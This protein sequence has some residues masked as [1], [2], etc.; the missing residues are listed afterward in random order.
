MQLGGGVDGNSITAGGARG[1]M[2]GSIDFADR[3]WRVGG[4]LA[5][6]GHGYPTDQ[7]SVAFE[8]VVDPFVD[9]RP[10]RST[11][12]RTIGEATGMKAAVER[13]QHVADNMGFHGVGA[14]R[15]TSR[16]LAAAN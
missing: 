10:F 11:T 13:P 7:P 14:H 4:G 3:R 1:E 2:V 8:C 6:L 15:G 16:S 12:L 5:H 9:V